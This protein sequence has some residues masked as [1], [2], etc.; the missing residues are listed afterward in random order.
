MQIELSSVE[1]MDAA[2]QGIR[3]RI[4]AMSANRQNIGVPTNR[5]WEQDII[6]AIGEMV[7]AKHLGIYWQPEV[8]KPDTEVGDVLGLQVRTTPYKNGHLV[9]NKTDNDADIF[10]LVTGNGAADSTWFIRG[11][12]YAFLGKKEKYWDCK[13]KNRYA[14]FVPQEELKSVQSLKAQLWADGKLSK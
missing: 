3:R 1:L 6:G 9:L 11:W 14:Y 7:L 2:T 4:S 12:Q 13:E 8:S 5:K 10:V